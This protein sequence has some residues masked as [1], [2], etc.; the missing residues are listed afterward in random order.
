MNQHFFLHVLAAIGLNAIFSGTLVNALDVD[1]NTWQ[2]EMLKAVNDLRAEYK[3]PAV[4][5]SM[6]VRVCL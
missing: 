4:G 1:T 3:K 2:Y 5:I 6:Y